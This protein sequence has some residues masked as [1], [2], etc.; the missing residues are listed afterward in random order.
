MRRRDFISLL[1]SAATSWPLAALAQQSAMPVVGFL[2]TGSL[3]SD[4]FRVAAVRQVLIE[5]GYVEGRNV[6]FEYRWAEDQYERLP[7]LAA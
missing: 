4:A 7:A 6:A 5:A 3:Q 1:S 2:G